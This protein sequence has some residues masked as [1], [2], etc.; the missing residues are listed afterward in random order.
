MC[1]NAL[2]VF[3]DQHEDCIKTLESI[4]EDGTGISYKNGSEN[5]YQEKLYVLKN[6]FIENKCIPH[7]I[8]SHKDKTADRETLKQKLQPYIFG[9]IETY[10][11]FKEGNGQFNIRKGF[12]F[13]IYEKIKEHLI[14]KKHYTETKAVCV[15]D[16][17]KSTGTADEALFLNPEKLEDIIQPSIEEYERNVANRTPEDAEWWFK[18]GWKKFKSLFG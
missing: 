16:F 9:F 17:L 18:R 7:E 3:S 2:L 15:V 6:H 5:R 4:L 13:S 1:L 12:D 14:E 11:K 10:D 8:C